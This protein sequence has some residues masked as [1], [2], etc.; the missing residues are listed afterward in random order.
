MARLV[1]ATDPAPGHVVSYRDGDPLNNQR[2]NLRYCTRGEAQR[3]RH[4]HACAGSRFKGVA[5][6]RVQL[7]W[8]AHIRVDRKQIYLGRF[9]TEEE[10]AAAYNRAALEHHGEYARLNE[11]PDV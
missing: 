6:D 4:K 7:R 8:R 2:A 5:Y 10:A 11:L 1:L 9:Q 3:N